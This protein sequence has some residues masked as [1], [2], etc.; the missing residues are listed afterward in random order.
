MEVGLE[1]MKIAEFYE[2]GLSKLEKDSLHVYYAFKMISSQNGHIFLYERDIFTSEYFSNI[3]KVHGWSIAPYELKSGHDDIMNF[4][5]EKE[6]LKKEEDESKVSTMS[7]FFLMRHYKAELNIK[8][9]VKK[10]LQNDKIHKFD[11]DF[12]SDDFSRVR[13]DEDQRKAAELC[14]AKPVVMVTGRGGTGKTEVVSIVINHIESSFPDMLHENLVIKYKMAITSS[15]TKSPLKKLQKR[16]IREKRL[17]DTIEILDNP[18]LIKEF[19][20]WLDENDH[21]NPM[22]DEKL[23]SFMNSLT[24]EEAEGE[25]ATTKKASKY[26]DMTYVLCVA[27]TGKA[28]SGMSKRSKKKAYTIH[29]V[30]ASYK[31][32]RIKQAQNQEDFPWKFAQVRV[33]AIDETSMVSPELLSSFLDCLMKECKMEKLIFL[34]DIDQLPSIQPGNLMEDLFQVLK[35]LGNFS[36]Q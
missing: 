32:Y 35:R 34:G 25:E 6:V 28:V 16:F 36:F 11:L 8:T 18:K 13:D 24:A 5:C 20:E 1:Q 29:Q 30:L 31:A 12:D 33:V 15:P 27:P 22:K 23:E 21:D 19:S 3:T 17:S 14:A 26:E 4:M 2:E 7:R 9:R 10:L